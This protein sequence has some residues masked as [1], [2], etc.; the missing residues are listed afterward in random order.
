METPV[1][2]IW[3]F[4]GLLEPDNRWVVTAAGEG[5]VSYRRLGSSEESTTRS[6]S[7][8]TTL[9]RRVDDGIAAKVPTLLAMIVM[10]G[11]FLN[12][13]TA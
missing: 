4:R 3:E 12:R 10:L 2:S 6:V 11:W 9:F 7:E 13:V 1:G 8:F 5:M